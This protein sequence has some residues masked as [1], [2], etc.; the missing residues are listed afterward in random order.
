MLLRNIGCRL[1]PWVAFTVEAIWGSILHVA[2]QQTGGALCALSRARSSRRD[3]IADRPR[4]RRRI[5]QKEQPPARPHARHPI[6]RKYAKASD[7]DDVTWFTHKLNLGVL[8]LLNPLMQGRGYVFYPFEWSM[9]LAERRESPLPFAG[10]DLKLTT[11]IAICKVPSRPDGSAHPPLSMIQPG[12]RGTGIVAGSA[13][14]AIGYVG[15]TDIEVNAQN[16]G[17]PLRGVFWAC[18]CMRALY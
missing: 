4:R 17:T 3:P 8:V 2:R 11:D 13:V 9:L 7:V 10:V 12:I 15:M 14:S 18:S 5:P 6:E 1:A 16:A